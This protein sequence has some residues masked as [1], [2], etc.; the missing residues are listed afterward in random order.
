MLECQFLQCNV[1]F[2][3]STALLERAQERSGGGNVP[4]TRSGF[5]SFFMQIVFQHLLARN[6]EHI[7]LACSASTLK[8]MNFL[9]QKTQNV[10]GP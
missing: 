7:V 10:K 3:L 4:L 1:S 2:Y 6:K 9:F 8:K 5:R